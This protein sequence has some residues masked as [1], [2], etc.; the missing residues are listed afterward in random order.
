MY[1]R[2][3]QRFLAKDFWPV[4]EPTRLLYLWF[5]TSMNSFRFMALIRW[6]P[7][8]FG[9]VFFAAFA[10]LAQT[11]PQEMQLRLNVPFQFVAYGDTRFTDPDDT[12]ASNAPVRRALVRAIADANPAFISIG[13]DIV[14]NGYDPN[15]WHTWDA[16]TALWR[17]RSIPVYPALG[18][19]D[20]HGSQKVALANYFQHFPDLKESRYYSVRAANTLV[21]VLDSSR[22]EVAGPQ[23]QWLTEKLD[24]IPADVEFVFIVLHHP[25][26]TSSSDDKV[27]GG[28]HSA[29]T[30]EQALATILEEG[31]PHNRARFGIFAA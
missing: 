20:L 31:L 11:P 1:T 25:P 14:Y 26:Y 28:G 2:A 23:G 3:E 19:H 16:E 9:A 13:G 29:R 6:F 12:E 30:S 5:L 7:A 21:L 17:Q 15:D 18:N 10:L 24:N 4:A 8:V 22:E 27:Y